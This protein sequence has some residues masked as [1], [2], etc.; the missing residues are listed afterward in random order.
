MP[1]S[2]KQ[3]AQRIKDILSQG[4]PG[5]FC[6]EETG[7]VHYLLFAKKDDKGFDVEVQIS[8]SGITV[9]TMG[10]DSYRF[11]FGEVD[12]RDILGLVDDLL[13]PHMR[14]REIHSIFGFPWRWVI[15]H[16]D[17][18]GWIEENETGLGLF[19]IPLLEVSDRN[20]DK[21]YTNNVLP[22]RMA[23]TDPPPP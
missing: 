5:E 7:G 18:T 12:E 20:S 15:E 22:G 2:A 16:W 10:L 11:D 23:K 14:I 3:L 6:S 9:F 13:S 8:D 19:P 4:F 1:D 21:F 17:G